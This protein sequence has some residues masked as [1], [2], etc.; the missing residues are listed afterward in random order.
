LLV[1]I[2]AFGQGPATRTVKEFPLER[3]AGAEATD[4]DHQFQTPVSTAELRRVL[5]C[6]SNPVIL[7]V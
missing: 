2:S 1:K 3:E 6:V 7:E 4:G 5:D